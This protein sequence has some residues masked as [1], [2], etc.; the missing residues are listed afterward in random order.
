MTS[1]QLATC[2]KVRSAA[3]LTINVLASGVGINVLGNQYFLSAPL[4][5]LSPRSMTWAFPQLLLSFVRKQ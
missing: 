2:L 4:A 3:A 1:Y 5:G